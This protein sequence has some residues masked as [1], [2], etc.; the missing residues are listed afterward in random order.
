MHLI[1]QKLLKLSGSYNLGDMALRDIAKIIGEEHPQ[2]IKHHLE[3]LE[4]KGLISWDRDERKILRTSNN[5]A[6]NI[7]F[8]VIPVLGAAN[9][10]IA[11]VFADESI[12]GHIKVSTRLIH[13]RTKVFAVQAVGSSMNKANIDGKSIEEGDYVIV[14]PVDKNIRSNDYVLS[15]IDDMA[16]IKKIS[17]DQKNEQIVLLSESSNP[18]P[19]IF[20][21]ESD[22]SKFLVNGK[23]IQVIKHSG[24]ES[25]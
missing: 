4:K 21:H 24:I 3:Q 23:V 13:N 17:I 20:L 15:I 16:N 11:S 2:L 12:I 14:D 9:C 22:A 19:P 7:D 25:L 8:I 1:Q 18:Y 10:G 6:S 5:P